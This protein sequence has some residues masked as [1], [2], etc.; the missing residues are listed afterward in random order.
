MGPFNNQKGPIL[1]LNI[2]LHVHVKYV[3]NHA[4]TFDPGHIALSADE[5]CG[6]MITKPMVSPV[7][8]VVIF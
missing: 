1:L 7:Q 2:D 8:L 6:V 4:G 3:T 5:T